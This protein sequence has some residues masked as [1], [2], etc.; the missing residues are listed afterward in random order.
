MSTI[1]DVWIFAIAIAAVAI[2]LII[3]DRHKPW[4]EK[5]RD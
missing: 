3:P 1:P 5:R 2:V 4:W